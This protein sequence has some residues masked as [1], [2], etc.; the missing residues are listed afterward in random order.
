MIVSKWMS[1]GLA[2]AAMMATSLALPVHA[3]TP[4]PEEDAVS[5][6]A[7]E[8]AS[9]DATEA[10]AAEKKDDGSSFLFI[11]YPITEPAIGSGLLAGPVWMRGGVEGE[12]GPD[13]PQAFGV[14]ALWTDGGSRGVIGFDHRAWG[15]SG[16][17]TTTVAA[18]LDLHLTFHGLSPGQDRDR[19]FMLAARGGGIKADRSL[20]DGHGIGFSIFSLTA[21]VDFDQPPPVELG[22]GLFKE[23]IAGLGFTWSHDTRDQLFTPST[24]HFVSAS[25]TAYTEA[26]GATFN[27]Q[28]YGAEW[29]GY[30]DGFGRGVLGWRAQLDTSHGDP[31]FYLRPYVSM[32]GVPA[33]EYAG[34]EVASVEGEFRWPVGQNWDLLAFGGV[35]T[36]RSTISG[37]TGRETVSA[38]GLGVRFKVKKY[39]GLTFGLDVADGPS[40]V[41]GYIQIGNAWS[42]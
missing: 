8:S 22:S 20:K 13:K 21:D 38:G 33:L 10:D 7:S 5:V 23:T 26:L 24:G 42:R 11:P 14:G 39:F 18:T 36:A 19:R 28:S 4:A 17:R 35:G 25:A 40:G 27:A 3:Q 12:S 2:M 16:W 9:G 31:P 41:V 1:P 37:F 6:S 34:Q 29:I 15:Q 32:R 30:K